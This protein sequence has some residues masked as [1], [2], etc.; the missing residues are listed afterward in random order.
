MTAL[1]EYDRLECPGL[2]RASPLDQKREIVVSLRDKSLVLSDPKTDMAVVHWSLPAMIREGAGLTPAVFRPGR[3]ATETL[4]LHDATMVTAL[5]R[6]LRSLQRRKPHP[7]RLRGFIFGC[8][9]VSVVAG[10][11]FWLPGALTRQT[12]AILPEPN[13]AELGQMALADLQHLTGSPCNGGLGQRAASALSERLLGRGGGRIM[14]VRDGLH[15]AL[16][17]PGGLVVISRDLVEAPPDA[18]TAAGFVLAALAARGDETAQ[19]ERFLTHAGLI[20]TFRLLTTGTLPDGSM[21]GIGEEL[22]AEA[23]KAPNLASD[24]LL[25]LFTQAQFSPRSFADALAGSGRLAAELVAGDPFDGISP[26]PILDDANWI[27]LQ[28]ICFDQ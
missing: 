28:S 22:V 23:T 10:C 13:R 14:V 11:V 7:G 6:V 16:A 5:D 25:A 20:A 17:L 4:E 2:W 9:T 12:A 1:N 3:D 15:G 18:E 24:Q 21:D 8:L 27:S 26:R 19:S